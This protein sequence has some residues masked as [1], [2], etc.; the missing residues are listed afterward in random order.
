MQRI[1]II[2]PGSIG[3]AAQMALLAPQFDVIGLADSPNIVSYVDPSE[4]MGYGPIAMEHS[5][6][7]DYKPTLK[8]IAW[9]RAL[10]E[11]DEQFEVKPKPVTISIDWAERSLAKEAA[12]R[13]QQPRHQSQFTKSQPSAAARKKARRRAKAGRKASR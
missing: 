12:W 1:A 10:A 8:E 6:E 3:I 11:Q 9:L 7:L 5:F 13:A 4:Q 2:G